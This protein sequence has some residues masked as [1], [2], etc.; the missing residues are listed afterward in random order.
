MALVY[1]HWKLPYW[2]WASFSKWR[3]L[4]SC[5]FVSQNNCSI[6][7]KRLGFFLWELWK[8]VPDTENYTVGR[9]AWDQL[10]R[11]FDSPSMTITKAFH[12]EHQIL[13]AQWFAWGPHLCACAH[14]EAPTLLSH[15]TQL[16]SVSKFLEHNKFLVPGSREVNQTDMFPTFTEFMI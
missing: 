12:K 13:Q 14:A 4:P 1:A 15:K 3:A 6:C 2:I 8:D 5:P 10:V 9:I 16:H 11:P 7:S